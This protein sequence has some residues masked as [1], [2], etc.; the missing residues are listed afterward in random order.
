[1]SDRLAVMDHGEIVQVGAP[2]DVYEAPC[3]GYVAA[4]LGVTNLLTAEYLGDGRVRVGVGCSGQPAWHR[5]A[6]VGLLYGLS[7]FG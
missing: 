4:F 6:R 2:R 5:S 1:M 7:G 3:N